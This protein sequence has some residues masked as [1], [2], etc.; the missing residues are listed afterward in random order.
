MRRQP[1][2]HRATSSAI[3]KYVS[4]RAGI[5]INAGRIRALGG[6]IRG[7][8]AFDPVVFRSTNFDSGGLLSGRCAAVRQRCSTDVAS[9]S[10]KPAGVENK[11]WVEGNRV[12]HMD[13][14]FKSTN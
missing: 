10:G 4:Q 8:E 11:P 3:V 9:G 2:F 6:L 14:G 1:G 13:Y 7:G 5:G 12:R